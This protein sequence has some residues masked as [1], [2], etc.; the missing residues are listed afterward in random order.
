MSNKNLTIIFGIF[1][2][3][4]A[5]ISR[6]APHPANVAPIAAIALFAG[7]YLDKRYAFILPVA[8]MLLSDIVVGFYALPIMFSVYGTFLLIGF[9]GIMIRK[10]KT[11]SRVAT[12]TIIGSL[13]FF[14]TTNAAVW[15]FGTMYPHTAAGL[16]QSYIMGLPFLKGTLFGDLFS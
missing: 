5:V 7:V 3:A 10:H 16:V 14:L 12:A 13:L 9:M 4:V 11:F 6:I 8:A 15:A 1:L 2:V